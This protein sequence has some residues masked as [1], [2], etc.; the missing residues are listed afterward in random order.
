MLLAR[1]LAVMFM[2]AGFALA[3]ADTRVARRATYAFYRW[4]RTSGRRKRHHTS[5]TR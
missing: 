4:R 3:A 5:G 1:I 2:G